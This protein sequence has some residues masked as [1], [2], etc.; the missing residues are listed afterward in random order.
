[1]GLLQ[2]SNKTN[3]LIKVQTH[4]NDNKNNTKNLKSNGFT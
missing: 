1:M 3:K 4:K 2:Q